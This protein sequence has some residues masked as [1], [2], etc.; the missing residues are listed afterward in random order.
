MCRRG[1][2]VPRATGRMTDLA[3]TQLPGTQKVGHPWAVFLAGGD[4]VRLRDLTMKIVGDDRPKQFCPIVGSESLLRQTRAR[5][6]PL[7][8]G[9]RQVFMVSQSHERYYSREL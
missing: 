5:L 1:A 7:F 4:G 2:P 9:D 6:D 3:N 8:S